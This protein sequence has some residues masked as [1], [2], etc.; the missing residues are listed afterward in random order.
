MPFG[1]GEGDC[2]AG[3]ATHKTV[4]FGN[5]RFPQFRESAYPTKSHAAR[6]YR[7]MSAFGGAMSNAAAFREETFVD[8]TARPPNREEV[9]ARYF[10]LRE[11]GKLHHNDVAKFLTKDA[12]VHHARRLGLLQ[13]KTFV[14]DSMDEL[15][16]AADLAIH[17]APPDRSR[18][19]DRYARAANLA[20]G[21]EYAAVLEAMRNARFAVVKVLQRH[22]SVGLI[23][24]DLAREI[25]LWLVDVSLEASLPDGAAFATRYCT[26]DAFAMTVGVGI[27][28]D[29][30]A[31]GRAIDAVPQL[32]RK[33][34]AEAVQDRRFAEAVYRGAIADGAMEGVQL[35]DPLDDE[36]GHDEGR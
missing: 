2:A 15:T 7:A 35:R 20:R 11:I 6:R 1:F 18:A 12:I 34:M 31:L 30:D 28:V 5:F 33:P 22:P 19:I 14:L 24:T 27:P 25:E 13:G 4:N 21:S 23:V 36:A 32:G 16:L 10:R 9:L 17:T 8:Q 26:P 29:R 3:G